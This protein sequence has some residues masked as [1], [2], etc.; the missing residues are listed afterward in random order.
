MGGISVVAVE[1]LD[2]SDECTQFHGTRWVEDQCFRLYRKEREETMCQGSFGQIA[3][4]NA[5]VACNWVA[6]EDAVYD[7]ME[8]RGID[9]EVYYQQAYDCAKEGNREATEELHLGED[10]L[11]LCWFNPGELW[12]DVTHL[13]DT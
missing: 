2:S 7:N 9:L 12:N 10:Y 8:K 1:N 5:K 11:P 3:T 13:C 6:V 4:G